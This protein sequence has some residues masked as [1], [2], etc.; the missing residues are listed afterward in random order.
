M[1]SERRELKAGRSELMAT[2]SSRANGI[3]LCLFDFKL[4]VWS[5]RAYSQQCHL[6]LRARVRAAFFADA[7]FS[8]KGRLAD[9]LPPIFPPFLYGAGLTRLP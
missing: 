8:A 3:F 7:D 4:T 1:R 5:S 6:F 9:A 2:V